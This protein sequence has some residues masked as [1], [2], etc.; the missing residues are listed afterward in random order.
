MKL[1]LPDSNQRQYEKKKLQT[2]IP[3]KHR[4]E[5]YEHD[6]KKISATRIQQYIQEN[7]MM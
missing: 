3:Y 1:V 5:I 2:N 7:F 6:I 4:C